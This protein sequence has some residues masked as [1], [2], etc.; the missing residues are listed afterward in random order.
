MYTSYSELD[1]SYSH[2]IYSPSRCHRRALYLLRPLK[3]ALAL[4]AIRC[5]PILLSHAALLPSTA[6]INSCATLIAKPS[7]PPP[8]PV[9]FLAAARI[10]S[11]AVRLRCR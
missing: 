11:T 1:L 5:T 8:M 10:H 2:T 6:A 7:L 9:L 3:L 4:T